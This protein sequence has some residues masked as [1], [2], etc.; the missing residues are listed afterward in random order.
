MR[1]L[2]LA[3]LSR[4]RAPAAAPDP[5]VLVVDAVDPP[6]ME[7]ELRYRRGWAVPPEQARLSLRAPPLLRAAEGDRLYGLLDS[8]LRLRRARRLPAP[9]RGGP[10]PA[11]PALRPLPLVID[12]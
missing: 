2:G 11:A 8:D 6:W 9:A 7:V 5:V 1:A 10:A 4:L 12:L 3:L